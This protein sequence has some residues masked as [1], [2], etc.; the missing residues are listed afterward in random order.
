MVFKFVFCFK[1]KNEGDENAKYENLENNSTTGAEIDDG[2]NASSTSKLK[3][4]NSMIKGRKRK[5]G[6]GNKGSVKKSN[7]EAEVKPVL[8]KKEVLLIIS[9]LISL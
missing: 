7:V 1:Q 4:E 9:E 8:T 3:V 6:K 5:V 2:V